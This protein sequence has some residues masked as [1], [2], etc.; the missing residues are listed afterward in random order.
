MASTSVLLDGAQQLRFLSA[1]CLRADT[2]MNLCS[3]SRHGNRS[4]LS[5]H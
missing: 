3:S 2:R 5:T 1:E 4:L